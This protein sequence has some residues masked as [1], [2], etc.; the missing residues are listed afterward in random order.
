MAEPAGVH[1]PHLQ[2]IGDLASWRVEPL[3]GTRAIGR[4]ERSVLQELAAL[5]GSMQQ[6]G[7]RA[8]PH[9]GHDHE[10]RDRHVRPSSQSAERTDPPRPAS[11][12][13][14]RSRASLRSP[15]GDP[16]E[17]AHHPDAHHDQGRREKA[18][19]APAPTRTTIRFMSLSPGRKA[20]KIQPSP[21]CSY[22]SRPILS[23]SRTIGNEKTASGVGRVSPGP[24]L[25]VAPASPSSGPP[26]RA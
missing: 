18:V 23:S 11:G 7:I 20:Q 13:P 14:H 15:R 8:E 22:S 12:L 4:N 2:Q 1:Q 9:H 5:A 17:K 21:T 10:N 16:E 24:A 6:E 25:P 19:H 3:P 26:G